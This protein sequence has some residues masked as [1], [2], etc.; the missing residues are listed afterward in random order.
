MCIELASQEALL[1]ANQNETITST[2][3]TSKFL[4]FYERVWM[5]YLKPEPLNGQC[6]LARNTVVRIQ[7]H[8]HFIKMLE[9]LGNFLEHIPFEYIFIRKKNVFLSSVLRIRNCYQNARNGEN[10]D[11]FVKRPQYWRKNSFFIGKRNCHFPHKYLRI[12]I[13]IVL[14]SYFF[15]YKLFPAFD[16]RLQESISLNAKHKL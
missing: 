2:W 4:Y 11:K 15:D 14:V 6:F 13:V 16:Q 8:R 7:F 10:S 12:V 3:Q 5:F 1:K 9:F